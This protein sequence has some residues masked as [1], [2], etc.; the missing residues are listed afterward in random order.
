MVM[1]IYVSGCVTTNPM[2]KTRDAP[3]PTIRRPSDDEFPVALT[4]GAPDAFTAVGIP[5]RVVNLNDRHGA[6]KGEFKKAKLPF[7]GAIARVFLVEDNQEEMD[8]CCVARTDRDI[9]RIEWAGGHRAPG[10]GARGDEAWAGSKPTTN[11]IEI[12]QSVPWL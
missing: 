9:F 4:E 12:N 10:P 11:F 3:G 2:G 6:E 7:I 5:A 1:Y 8:G